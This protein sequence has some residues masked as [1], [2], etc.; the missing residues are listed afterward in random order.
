MLDTTLVSEVLSGKP[1]ILLS[2]DGDLLMNVKDWI[3]KFE[4]FR[5]LHYDDSSYKRIEK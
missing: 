1:N 2:N 4:N 5:L 3:D